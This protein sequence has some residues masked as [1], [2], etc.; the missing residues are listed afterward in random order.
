LIGL[1]CAL[2]AAAAACSPALA[3]TFSPGR[4]TLLAARSVGVDEAELW[5]EEFL[6]NHPNVAS[7]ERIEPGRIFVVTHGG[8][9]IDIYLDNLIKLMDGPRAEREARLADFEAYSYETLAELDM[10]PAPTL[11]NLM[12]IV[13]PRGFVDGLLAAAAEVGDPTAAPVH[14]PLAGDLYV[15]LAFDTPSSIGVTSESALEALGLDGAAALAQA[16]RNFADYAAQTLVW[17][18]EQ[19]LRIAVLDTNYESSLL[20]LDD[21]WRELETEMGGPLAVAVP[22]RG[23]LVVGRADD[24]EHMDILEGLAFEAPFNPYPLSARVFV[25]RGGRWEALE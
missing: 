9:E 19:G 15:V 8:T 12:P 25:R 11:E 5:A 6:A 24:P 22:S 20:L 2:W 16:R 3:Q 13:R 1:A 23:L 21:V 14:V 18:E 17:E 7:F 10:P 4:D